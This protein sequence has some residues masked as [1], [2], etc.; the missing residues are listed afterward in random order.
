MLEP[1]KQPNPNNEDADDLRR[2]IAKLVAKNPE[3]WDAAMAKLLAPD[4]SLADF[5][6]FMRDLAEAIEEA[7]HKSPPA[8]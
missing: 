3:Y 5:E 6:A 8:H 2:C 4:A 7:H 1:T